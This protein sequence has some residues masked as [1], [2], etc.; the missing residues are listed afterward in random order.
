MLRSLF[1]AILTPLFCILVGCASSAVSRDAAK[2]VDLGVQNA[3]DLVNNALDNDVAESYQNAN[4]TAKGAIIGGAAGAIA[5][6]IYSGLG[7]I[8]GTAI[9]AI[10]GASYGAYIDSTT[11]HRDRLENRGVNIIILGDQILIVMHSARI[12]EPYTATIKTQ[13][14]ST[15]D[16]VARYI[17]RFR[18][19]LVKVTGYTND[20]G[21]ARANLALSKQQADNVAKYLSRAGVNAR[22]LYSTGAGCEHL[23]DDA[24]LGWDESDNYRIEITLQKLYV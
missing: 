18:T 2:N 11:D 5:G 12:F 24:A 6:S 19:I 10:F 23:V 1:I 9:G 7:V 4:Q 14:Y 22:I 20:T 13:S 8:P 21:N 16:M 17:N 3:K 15:L